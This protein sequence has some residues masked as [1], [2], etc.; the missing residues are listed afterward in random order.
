MYK[1]EQTLFSQAVSKT[2]Y[3]DDNKVYLFS[4]RL[5][6]TRKLFGEVPDGDEVGVPLDFVSNREF[7]HSIVLYKGTV[8]SHKL[9]TSKVTVL[10]SLGVSITV[11]MVLAFEMT[12]YVNI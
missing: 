8:S 7:S 2:Q 11:R 10:L 5:K 6:I 4:Q 3:K 12:Q 1:Q 9:F